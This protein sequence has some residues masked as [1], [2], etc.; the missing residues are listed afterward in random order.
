MLDRHRPP[1]RVLGL[2]HRTA[3]FGHVSM[4]EI[5]LGRDNAAIYM[6]AKQR[7]DLTSVW[8]GSVRRLLLRCLLTTAA[9]Q[10]RS[11]STLHPLR[12]C[13]RLYR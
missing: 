12:L 9:G 13:L 7:L 6:G 1:R 10:V 5:R 8:L 2:N 11:T 3:V 4:Q